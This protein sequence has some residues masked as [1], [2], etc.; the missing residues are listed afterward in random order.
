MSMC[1]GEPCPH[2]NCMPSAYVVTIQI[3]IIQAELLAIVSWSPVCSC[4]K[5]VPWNPCM[6]PVWIHHWHLA[7]AIGVKWTISNYRCGLTSESRNIPNH[8]IQTKLLR[9]MWQALGKQPNWSRSILVLSNSQIYR[10]QCIHSH[11]IC[12]FFNAHNSGMERGMCTLSISMRRQFV[13][14]S[15]GI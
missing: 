6:E 2:I 11:N 13:A 4:V 8:A 14:L 15:S 10:L 1:N 9:I 5:G 12:S 7:I 3:T